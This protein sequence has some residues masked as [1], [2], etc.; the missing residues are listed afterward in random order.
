LGFFAQ[1]VGNG[2]ISYYLALILRSVGVT[3][4]ENQ[5]LIT[6]CMQM[7][8]LLFAIG[9]SFMI[10]GFGRR[11]LFLSSAAIMLTSY[12]LVTALSASFAQS[13][14]T[15]TATGAAVIPFLFIFFASYSSAL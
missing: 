1:W 7:W 9:G 10:D 12:V 15:A 8:N 5:L 11:P 13:G 2:V 4:V 14:N 3:S 6:A